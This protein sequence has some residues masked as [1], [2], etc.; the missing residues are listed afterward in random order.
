MPL[1]LPE[2]PGEHVAAMTR[3][4]RALPG[5][6]L[7]WD[8]VLAGRRS[9]REFS[10]VRP[11]REDLVRALERAHESQRGQWPVERHGQAGLEVLLAVYRVTGMK[12]G[13][14]AGPDV[15]LGSPPWLSELPGRYADAPVLALVCG[16]FAGIDGEAYGGLLVRAGALGY[17]L[18]LAA[19]RI[20]LEGSAFGRTSGEVTKAA[21]PG[22]R[23]LFTIAM[24]Y[25]P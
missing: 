23:H 12:P 5:A 4:R 24:G 20:G 13:L 2:A 25:A 6:D 7:P 17:A 9:V 19:R 18:W 22:S 14:Y 3:T 21:A 16:R 15:M 10:A 11:A 8:S 1:I